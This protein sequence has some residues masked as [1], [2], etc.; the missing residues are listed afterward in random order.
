MPTI[1]ISGSPSNDPK[2]NRGAAFEAYEKSQAD[3]AKHAGAKSAAFDRQDREIDLQ[4]SKLKREEAA[5][6]KAQI[7]QRR[8]QANE[9]ARLFRQ[10]MAVRTAALANEKA[11]E[12]QHLRAQ[13]VLRRSE[14][15]AARRAAQTDPYTYRIQ[16]VD[17]L[18]IRGMRAAD[19]GSWREL[20]RSERE[21]GRIQNLH[22]TNPAVKAAI[23]KAKARIAVGKE[24]QSP[25]RLAV[26]EGLGLFG[27]FLTSPLVAT[28]MAAALGVATAPMVLGGAMRKGLD[29]T[30]PYQRPRI[31]AM[32]LGRAGGFS[33]EDL[34]GRM[35]KNGQSTPQWMRDLGITP[36][37]GMD[38]LDKYGIGTG[39][40]RQAEGLI[41]S[42]GQAQ[43]APFLGG[44]GFD[45]YAGMASF[46]RT[47]GLA[48]EGGMDAY[49]RKFQSVSVIAQAQGLDKSKAISNIEGL[50][51]QATAGGGNLT[52]GL[53][54]SVF[55][56]WKTLAQSGNSSMRSGEGISRV[57]G[58]FQ[59]A[60]N[61]VGFGGSTPQNVAVA[62]FIS[63][64]GGAQSFGKGGKGWAALFGSQAKADEFAAA[65]PDQMSLI[66]TAAQQ[67]PQAVQNAIGAVL[68]AQPG[69]MD[70]IG[71]YSPARGLGGYM[72]AHAEAV[73]RGTSFWDMQTQRGAEAIDSPRAKEVYN[74]LVAKGYPPAAASGILA[75]MMREDPN[76][77]PSTVN[78]AGMKGLMQWNQERQGNFRR[79]YGFD[80][81]QASTQQQIDFMDSEMQGPYKGVGDQ[82][83]SGTLSADQAGYLFSDQNEV[84][85]LNPNV[86]GAESRARGGLAS[87]IFAAR[88]GDMSGPNKASVMYTDSR[89]QPIDFNSALVNTA[90]Q[91]MTGGEEA[92]KLA[93][94]G[95]NAGADVFK[96]F[97]DGVTTLAGGI[98]SFVTGA[99]KFA[100]AVETFAGKITAPYQ[101]AGSPGAMTGAWTPEFGGGIGMDYALPMPGLGPRKN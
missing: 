28:A 5:E 16:N 99:D 86:R 94:P 61:Q 85:S 34:L 42:V 79:K 10:E 100:R 31:S 67:G 43:Y 49:F 81:S 73:T 17:R 78:S 51:K 15:M 77:S 89:N 9:D 76:L 2:Q 39:G 66:Y 92:S 96:N 14:D 12:A 98:T 87:R 4:L 75:N 46:G 90:V 11:R 63:Q 19:T 101:P 71:K 29:F 45:K 30:L 82:L 24:S 37:G 1:N 56:L 52:G 44:M 59:E 72:G 23:E 3:A 7:S 35:Y 6:I 33:G 54:D 83:R 22:G 65:N 18:G 38:I 97:S 57:L 58:G 84:P 27:D 13:R 91:Q 55:Q 20:H 26:G 64:Q 95:I 70:T 62:N 25:G 47:A 21:L 69:L 48:D 50:L 68:Q 74:M 53:S 60:A 8:A 36:Q 88:N 40:P 32:D 93:I 80:I 41:R